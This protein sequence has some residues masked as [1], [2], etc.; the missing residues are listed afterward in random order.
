MQHADIYEEPVQLKTLQ[1]VLSILQSKLHPED[2]VQMPQVPYSLR[3]GSN[4][5]QC[6]CWFAQSVGIIVYFIEHDLGTY[7][8]K[9]KTRVCSSS[10]LSLFVR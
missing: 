1:T 5:R 9:E 2:E 6:D 8:L 3:Y 4:A 7:D 10:L